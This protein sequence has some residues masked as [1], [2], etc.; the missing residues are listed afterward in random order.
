MMLAGGRVASSA[1]ESLRANLLTHGKRILRIGG[2]HCGQ[3]VL[4]LNGFLILPGLIN[5]HDHLEF[6]LFPRLGDGPYRNSTQWANEIYKPR[7]APVSQ[8]L[9]IPQSVRLIWGGI[10]NLLSGVTTVSHHNPYKPEVF[11]HRFPVRVIKRFG[12]AHSLRFCPDVKEQYRRTPRGAPFIIHAGEGR[13]AQAR[14]EIHELEELQVLGSCTVIVHGVAFKPEDL[15]LISRRGVSLVWCP[16]SNRFTLGRTLSRETLN[17]GIPIALGSDSAL[18]ADGD[19]IDELRA[20]RRHTNLISLYKMVTEG[21]A[22]ILRLNFG[23][24]S[25]REGGVADFVAVADQGQT[26]AEALV[27]FRPELV[28]LGGRIKLFSPEMACRLP[29][30]ETS[31]FNPIEL[32]GRGRWFIDLQPSALA[33]DVKRELGAAFRLAGRKVLV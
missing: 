26:P 20:G 27:S 31:R 1:T 13:D 21:A 33:Q 10:K 11:E 9:R 14:K 16:S 7:E 25:I 29:P 24:G 6:N 15:V 18:T 4:D 17:S 2:E 22:R 28:V 12:W 3:P 30:K 19:F 23:E 5:A 32:E 8:Q